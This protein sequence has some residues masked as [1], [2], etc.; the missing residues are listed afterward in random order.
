MGFREKGGV[1]GDGR[2]RSIVVVSQRT[3]D[4]LIMIQIDISKGFDLVRG[5]NTKLPEGSM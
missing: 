4:H 3:P 1:E 5:I 2:R